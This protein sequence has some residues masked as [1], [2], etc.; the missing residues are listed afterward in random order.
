MSFPTY[1]NYSPVFPNPL[2]CLKDFA[3]YGATELNARMPWNG[4]G[5]W[6][7]ETGQWMQKTFCLDWAVV[8]YP[9]VIFAF[10]TLARVVLNKA[11]IHVS[12]KRGVCFLFAWLIYRTNRKSPC[13]SS[14][15]R[16]ERQS[17]PTACGGCS[18]IPL[19]GSGPRTSYSSETSSTSLTSKAIGT[20]SSPLQQVLKYIMLS[21][22]FFFFFAQNGTRVLR[23]RL[24]E[25]TGSTCLNSGSTTTKHTPRST[26]MPL[27]RTSH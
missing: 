22:F 19:R 9:L 12:R 21:R 10:I 8:L 7:A 25:F 20:V 11:L 27:G 14:L 13:G 2:L 1:Y 17:S 4:L 6:L 15:M 16:K 5:V 24:R 18:C 3:T 26:W 23:S